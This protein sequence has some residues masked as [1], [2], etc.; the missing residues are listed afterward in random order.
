M[1]RVPR[2]A[3]FDEQGGRLRGVLDLAAGRYPGF[4]F[5]RPVGDILPIFHFHET[6]PAALEPAF[7][8]LR[9]NNYRT[10]GTDALVR[11]VRDGKHPG[12]GSVMLNFDDAW[13]SLW[14]VVGPLLAKYGLSAVTF[15]IPGRLADA[16]A[17]RSTLSDGPVDADAADRAQNPFVTWPEL[18]ALASSGRVEV[19]SHSWSHSMIFSAREPLGVV[20]PE[21]ASEPVL[22]R[23]RLNVTGAPVFLEPAQLGH[24]LYA[25]RSRLSGA[26]RFLPDEAACAALEQFITDQ[27]GAAF[28]AR[29]DADAV[30]RAMLAAIGGA[31]ESD[32]DRLT[33]IDEELVRAREELEA[34]LAAPVR[35]V[36][37]PW[38]VTS[39][40]TL[41]A[42]ER[43]GFLTA[44]ANRRAG[45][46]AVSAGDDP[47]FL[48]RL[49]SRHIFAL[50][51]R[52][53]R[54]FVTLA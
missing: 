16:A 46:L 22:V 9:D 35:H 3:P 24:P 7:A 40:D 25:R 42:L 17:V 23:P 51:G 52:G 6:T 13:A 5:G 26:R 11:F 32:A 19:Q 28:F 8:Y 38:G 47:F 54:V 50:P 21:F 12:P 31:W 18:R 45:R 29:S 48:K 53:R 15:A 41:A 10:V 43:L 36:C 20:T 30:L 37:L 14:L 49:H 33:A 44:I 1:P 34:R 27:G 39:P 4:L 2:G